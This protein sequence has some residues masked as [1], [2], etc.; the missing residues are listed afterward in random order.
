MP[1][2][3]AGSAALLAWNLLNR[4]GTAHGAGPGGSGRPQESEASARQGTRRRLVGLWAAGGAKVRFSLGKEA[5]YLLVA[6]LASA[7][8]L[9]RVPSM[10]ASLEVE[11]LYPA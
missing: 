3:S 10:I 9:L 7:A 6:G 11:V 5:A 2:R 4:K 1:K 8:A